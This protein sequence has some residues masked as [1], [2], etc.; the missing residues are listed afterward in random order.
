MTYQ[1]I[2]SAENPAALSSALAAAILPRAG[3]KPDDHP[4][5]VD[6]FIAASGTAIRRFTDLFLAALHDS[7]REQGAR[8]ISK[9]R[10]L[11]PHDTPGSRSETGRMR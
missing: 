3:L 1:R 9:H 2:A 4:N 7:R 8:E 10:H 6:R 11:I 5:L